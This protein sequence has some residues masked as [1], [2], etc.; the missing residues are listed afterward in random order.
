VSSSQA[1][2]PPRYNFRETE[3]KWQKAWEDRQTFRAE[4]DKARPKY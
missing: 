3:A 4:M 2:Q 1:A